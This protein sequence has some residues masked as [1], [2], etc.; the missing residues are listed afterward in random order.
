[1]FAMCSSGLRS[2]RG[3]AADL[4]SMYSKC[5]SSSQA[6]KAFVAKTSASR[7]NK[8]VRPLRYM[9]WGQAKALVV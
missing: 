9:D 6:S 4:E 7:A 1:M 8:Y 5:P 2:F 3:M